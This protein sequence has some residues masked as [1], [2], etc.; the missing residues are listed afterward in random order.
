MTKPWKEFRQEIVRLYIQ[1][2]RTLHDVKEIMRQRH[3]FEASIR[4]YRQHFDD[5]GVGKYNCKKR[6]QRRSSITD[7]LSSAS[8]SSPPK[9]PMLSSSAL[10]SSRPF[11]GLSHSEYSYAI[12]RHSDDG[13]RAHRLDSNSFYRGGHRLS[14][15][16]LPSPPGGDVYP[17]TSHR[18]GHHQGPH[19][20]H[21]HHHRTGGT[22]TDPGS[23]HFHDGRSANW[24]S[25]SGSHHMS[26]PASRGEEPAAS[27]LQVPAR[28]PQYMDHTGWG[29]YRSDTASYTGSDTSDSVQQLRANDAPSPQLVPAYRETLDLGSSQSSSAAISNVGTW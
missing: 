12:R 11:A 22:M 6:Q 28:L 27:Y 25:S 14:L 1:E 17:S 4:S 24:G 29:Y 13:Y 16:T 18:W 21:H 8:S 7:M 26:P 5:W 15:P 2:G 20:H 10:K 23:W 9:T 19:N 3:G